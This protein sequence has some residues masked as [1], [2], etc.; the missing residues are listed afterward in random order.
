VSAVYFFVI[1]CW[2]LLGSYILALLLIASLVLLLACLKDDRAQRLMIFALGVAVTFMGLSFLGHYPATNPHHVAW[3]TGLMA[4]V[5]AGAV[6]KLR[7]GRSFKWLRLGLGALLSL[8]LVMSV[9]STFRKWPPEMLAGSSDALIEKLASM[10]PSDVVLYYGAFRLVPL[11]LKRGEAIGHHEY[12]PFISTRS[13]I[14]E[15]KYFTK[16]YLEQ[17]RDVL[18]REMKAALENDP[19]GWAKMVIV[20]RM[21]KDFRVLG[22]FVLEQKPAQW[23]NFN[24]VAMNVSWSNEDMR[25]RGLAEALEAR[26]CRYRQV[27]V[28]PSTRSEG[29]IMA[30][31]C[32]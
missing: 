6:I 17:N 7:E 26:N 27:L 22:D 2:K 1:A 30:V 20:L 9:V 23:R 32:P 28:V 31:S 16:S 3:L 21:I 25:F 4:I 11:A 18:T 12:A 29:F 14:V 19:L 15:P 24:V 13:G 10:P 5:V 8:V